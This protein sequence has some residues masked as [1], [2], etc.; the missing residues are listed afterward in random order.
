MSN[1]VDGKD[2]YQSFL[3]GLIRC[4][5]S[6]L[7]HPIEQVK[8]RLQYTNNPNRIN[9]W[10]VPKWA[11]Q[12]FK[13]TGSQ[14]HNIFSYFYRGYS[15]TLF[16]ILA[17]TIYKYPLLIHGPKLIEQSVDHVHTK[18]TDNLKKKP[19]PILYQVALTPF[20][21]VVDTIMQAPTRRIKYIRI[22][23]T[24]ASTTWET[25]KY[26]NKGRKEG[27]GFWYGSKAY[28]IKH[29]IGQ[30]SLLL[31]DALIR[32]YFLAPNPSLALALAPSPSPSLAPSPR[33]APSPGLAGLTPAL[34]PR[35]YLGRYDYTFSYGPNINNPFYVAA[36]SLNGILLTF[37]TNPLD[38][39][40]T[41]IGSRTMK[42]QKLGYFKTMTEVYKNEGFYSL[43]IGTSLRVLP[44]TVTVVYTSLAISWGRGL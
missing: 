17:K 39:V 22:T 18:L 10:Q 40:M 21:V 9:F 11:L 28:F 20:L 32:E 24:D 44:R 27:L 33:L 30:A 41:R 26:L 15:A 12:D 34:D 19:H 6:I 1:K 5:T 4:S 37:L 29:G 2:F 38:V 42:D 36:I 35:Q 16:S 14:N 8:V 31:T 43:F 25:V 23:R 13:T 7:S 3:P